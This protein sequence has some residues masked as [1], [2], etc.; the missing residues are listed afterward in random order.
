VIRTFVAVFPPPE[1][2]EALFQAA[3]D[4]QA[5][6]DFRLVGQE[7]IHLTLKF[8]GDV[9]EDDLDS[10]KQVLK[11]IRENHDPFEASTSTFGAFP[12]EKKARIL[13]AGIEEGQEHLRAMAEEVDNLLEPAG[14]ERENRPYVPHLTLGRARTRRTTLDTTETSPPAVRFTVSG[15][16]LVESA[17]GK[18]GVTYS[19]LAT[20]PFASSQPVSRSA[21][22]LFDG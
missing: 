8:L 16:D 5:S 14:F 17:P 12:T 9:A 1:V 3:R 20:Y 22:Q 11:P 7:K 2:R 13:W 15:V 19:I 21:L 6:R 18:N 4:L 10:V